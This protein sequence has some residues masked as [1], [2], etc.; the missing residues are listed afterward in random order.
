MSII[1]EDVPQTGVFC[2]SLLFFR[3]VWGQFSVLGQYRTIEQE[4]FA[5]KFCV[6]T[7]R[8]FAAIL[9]YC[10]KS[11]QSQDSKFPQSAAA[12]IVRCCLKFNVNFY[13]TG[14][15]RHSIIYN[16]RMRLLYHNFRCTSTVRAVI[17]PRLWAPAAPPFQSMLIITRSRAEWKSK[18][19]R[20]SVV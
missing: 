18:Q 13:A 12:L 3:P 7:R 11:Q 5:S 2:D 16:S 4:R 8:G 6:L 10:K 9:T 14:G 17:L 1:A 15:I 19:D 20:K